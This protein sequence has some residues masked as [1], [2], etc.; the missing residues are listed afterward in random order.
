[1]SAEADLSVARLEGAVL[2]GAGWGGTAVSR[3]RPEEG[4]MAGAGRGS[5]VGGAGVTSRGGAGRG[6]YVGGGGGAGRGSNVGAGGGVAGRGSKAGTKSAGRRAGVIG[7]TG[8]GGGG[9][10]AGVGAARGGTT[11]AGGGASATSP[12]TRVG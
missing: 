10:G 2:E 12:A 8:G 11:V 3:S 9:G 4:R 7:S 5:Y 6:S 1:M